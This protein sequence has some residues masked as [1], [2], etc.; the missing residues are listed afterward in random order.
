M[1]SLFSE[2][3]AGIA[4]AL[5]AVEEEEEEAE[6]EKVSHPATAQESI[7]DAIGGTIPPKE[8]S[9]FTAWVANLGESFVVE[10][11]GRLGTGDP[12]GLVALHRQ[13]GRLD[14]GGDDVVGPAGEEHR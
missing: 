11:A 7:E 14:M 13:L 6:E 8:W 9:H 1:L 2:E 3:L 10:Q 5:I 4:G 12:A